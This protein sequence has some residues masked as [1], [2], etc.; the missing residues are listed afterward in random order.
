[1]KLGLIFVTATFFSSMLAAA[2]VTNYGSSEC[3]EAPRNTNEAIGSEI[4]VQNKN[5]Y[6]RDDTNNKISDAGEILDSF[7]DQLKAFV[8]ETKFE[9]QEFEQRAEALEHKLEHI[10]Q[11]VAKTIRN[12]KGL[13]KQ[14]QFATHMF[15]AMVESIEPLKHY[16]VVGSP[17]QRILFY[18]YQLNVRIFA[19]HDSHG[20]PDPTTDKYELKVASFTT[21]LRYY[22]ERFYGLSNLSYGVR[23]M[24]RIQRTQ[25]EK[26]LEFLRGIVPKPEPRARPAA[27][28]APKASESLKSCFKF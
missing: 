15:Q 7:F 2:A 3:E 25:A 14:L 8:H 26:T 5:L 6:K 4:I 21:S 10:D 18:L 12:K 19:L 28:W 9:V 17:D 27:S 22:T 23:R 24:F 16:K 20:N 13:S 1:M 11:L